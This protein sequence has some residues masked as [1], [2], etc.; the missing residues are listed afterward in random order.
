MAY[1]HI[2]GWMRALYPGV[3]WN[4]KGA[5]KVL[6]LSFDDG[7]TP[8]ITE[9]T[10]EILESYQA[11]STFFSLGRN[12]DRHPEVYQKILDKG[13]S[14]GNH[15]YSH[16]KGWGTPNEIYYK[17]IELAGHSVKSKLFRPP[18]GRIRRSQI[19]HLSQKYEIVL[20]DVMSHD[21]EAR[22]S[23]ERSLRA[24]LK[25][26]KE[27]SIVVFHDSVKAWPK[28]KYILPRVLEHFSEKGFKFEAILNS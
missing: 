2:D 9:K 22:L 12:V 20:W 24:V 14:T 21:Y 18:Y 1:W 26:A 15:T 27:G 11:K 3:T 5:G 16:L 6:Y 28:L 23:K 17:D 4:R 19:R 13:H 25:Y 8:D 7:P 10:L